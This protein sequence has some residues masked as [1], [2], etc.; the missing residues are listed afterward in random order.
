MRISTTTIFEQGIGGITQQTSDIAKLQNQINSNKRILTPSDDPIA[1]ARVLQ[2][3]QSQSLTEQYTK[4]SQTANDALSL[5]ESVLNDVTSLIQNV[6][7][8]A[9]NAGNASLNNSDRAT[10]ASELQSQYDTLL[11]LANSTDGNGQYLFSGF[12]GAT[13]P[14]SQTSAGVVAYNGDDG[15]RQIQISPS[16]QVPVSSS[17]A[18][19][20]QRI[21]NGNGTFVTTAG[22]TNTG[23]GVADLGVVAD[24]VK[25]NASNRDFTIKFNQ[26]TSVAPSVT[27]YDIVDNV[28]GNSL[29]T[30]LAPAAA[31]YPRTYTSATSISLKSQGSEPAFDF[32]TSLTIE[33]QPATG[34]TFSVKSS[35]NQDIF[36]TINNLIATLKVPTATG[37]GNATLTNQLNKTLTSLDLT[38]DVVLSARAVG[39]AALNEV[40]TQQDTNDNLVLQY[41]TTISNL[42]DLDI[43]QAYSQSTLKQTALQAALKSF[44]QTQSLSLFNFI[45]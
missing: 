4:N 10:I 19:I 18:D 28:T 11:G 24:A 30:G 29:L 41:K 16:R 39:G 14:F 26:D 22:S 45:Q 8:L 32:G 17:G 44:S 25:W 40:K 2:V 15:E 3:S 6:R 37:T 9:V 31:P 7:T 42:Q 33:G 13:K 38:Q 34:D 5:R 35:A 27:T 1:S 43:V 21:R 20:F 12:Q 36:T 23:T